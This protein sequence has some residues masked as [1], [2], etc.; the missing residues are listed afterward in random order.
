MRGHLRSEYEE[1]A[2][3]GHGGSIDSNW[4]GICLSP[5]EDL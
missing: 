4:K 5:F 3:G 1:D 2:K